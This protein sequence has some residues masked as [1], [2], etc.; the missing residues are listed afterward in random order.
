MDSDRRVREAM[1][2]AGRMATRVHYPSLASVD[3]VEIA[4]I[5]WMCGGE[6]M[7][8][9]STMKS[10]GVPDRNFIAATLHFDTGSTGLLY[11]DGDTAGVAYDSRTV[12]GSDDFHV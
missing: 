3:D 12:A 2:G 11:N 7:E 8:I 1:V 4:A 9:A 5:R 6:V 10:V